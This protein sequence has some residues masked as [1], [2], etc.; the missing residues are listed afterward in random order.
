MLDEDRRRR[1]PRDP[2]GQ[3]VVARLEFE[4]ETSDDAGVPSPVRQGD[5]RDDV[6]EAGAERADQEQRQHEGRHGEEHVAQTHEH[7]VGPAAIMPERAPTPRPSATTARGRPRRRQASSLGTGDQAGQD[8]PP[9]V[10]G[11]EGVDEAR[12]READREVH[13]QG[14]VRRG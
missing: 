7:G 12:W 10:V 2:G 1:R 8:V 6:D 3:D 11:A 14:V 5:G 4:D 13:G 9:E